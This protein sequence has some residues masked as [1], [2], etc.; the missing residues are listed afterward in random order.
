[1]KIELPQYNWIIS[2]HEGRFVT[3]R[4]SGSLG[5][6]GDSGC[7]STRTFN[8]R[9]YVDTKGGEEVDF[10]LVAECFIIEPWNMGG[11]QTNFH[12]AEFECS[13]DGIKQAEKW[14]SETSSKTGF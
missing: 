9:A 6:L 12:Q 4:Y 1:M 7:I 5:T 3:N 13:E 10:R 11:I 2:R 8:Y 14:L